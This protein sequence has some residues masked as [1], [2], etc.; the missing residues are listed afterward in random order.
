MA[1]RT[2]LVLLAPNAHAVLHDLRLRYF[3]NLERRMPAHVTMLFPFCSPVDELAIEAISGIGAAARPFDASFADVGR[4]GDGVVW[5]RP[6]PA[7]DFDQLDDLVLA[8]FPD[9]LPSA[10]SQIGRTLHLTV[11]SRLR[12]AEADRLVDEV[13]ALLPIAE[14]IDRI[15]LMVEHD[16]GWG[17]E[18]SWPLGGR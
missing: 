11:A 7:A 16:G 18:R 10:R 8:S 9:C 14:R 13:R 6:Q 2:A 12:G 17:I 15:T 4:F 5:L 3:R 1:A